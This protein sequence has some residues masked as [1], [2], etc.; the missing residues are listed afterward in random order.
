MQIESNE[1]TVEFCLY[2]DNPNWSV[3]DDNGQGDEHVTRWTDS[4]TRDVEKAKTDYWR[5][6]NAQGDYA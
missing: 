3:V 1:V 4:I 6:H 5:E 2:D